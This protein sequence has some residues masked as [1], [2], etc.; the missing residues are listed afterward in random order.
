[1]SDGTE[2]T[3][4]LADRLA[5]DGHLRSPRWRR[6]VLDTPRHE[7]LRGGFFQRVD[8]D[9]TTGWSPVMPTDPAWLPATYADESLVTQIAGTVV[10]GD[11]HGRIHRP[12][13]S[14]STMPGLV[15]RMLE[16]LH[17]EDGMRVL[18]IGTGTGYS[19]ALLC[20]RLGDGLVTS[21]DIDEGVSVRARNALGATGHTPRLLVGDGLAGDPDGGPYDRIV[22]TCGVLEVPLAWLAQ[23]R[24]GGRILVTVGGWMYAS[25]LALLTVDGEGG[26]HGRLLGGQVSFMQAR[27]HLPPPL[28]VLPDLAAGEERETP[29]GADSLDDWTTRF[30]AQLAAP[31]TQRIRVASEGGKEV[32]VLLDADAGSWATLRRDGARWIVSQGGED[33]LWDTVEDHVTRWRR[34]GSPDLDDF[35]ITVAPDGQTI[36]WP[37]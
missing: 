16:E 15:V 2:L 25:E 9:G 33:R 22:A 3:R 1:M 24:P 37:T 35:R 30:V 32:E 36:T 7:F 20:H 26:A 8:G 27:P 5:A 23:V 11:L 14:S 29:V 18:E 12:P 31:R 19:T 28:G 34:T 4:G 13:T 17:V 10:P 6:A 21:I